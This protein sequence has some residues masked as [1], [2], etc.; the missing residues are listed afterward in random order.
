MAGIYI[1]IPF[2]KQACHYC[3]FHFSTNLDREAAVVDA[4][5]KEINLR[6]DFLEDKKIET[7]YLGGGTPSLISQE[8]FEKL[9]KHLSACFD[10]G[11]LKEFTLEANPDDISLEHLSMWKEIG[12]D[13]FSLGVQ[14]FFDEDLVYMN[15]SHNSAQS[16]KSIELIKKAKFKNFSI[17]LIYGGHT[18][19]AGMLLTNI[20]EAV[21]MDIPH[22]SVY[23]M[24]V[25]KKTALHAFIEKGDLEK[26]DNSKQALQFTLLMEQ[27]EEEGFEQY[28]ISNYC[29]DKKYAVH[30]TNYWK[31]K[32]YL[33]FGP[34]AHSFDGNQRTWNIA[35]NNAYV[36][37]IESNSSFGTNE[38]LS[39]K[40]K[41][42]EY[43][44]TGFRTKWGVQLKKIQNE[45]ESFSSNFELILEKQ[46]LAKTI[47]DENGVL[48]L[49]PDG[50][51]IADNVIAE[52]FATT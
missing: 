18:T 2:C 48:T 16:Y 30:N 52:F 34:S 9:L 45:F 20:N 15:R 26:L 17:D 44:L 23:G 11:D 13:R 32:P 40:D 28:E 1:H 43:L 49:T 24:T 38:I 21:Q 33:G 31:A 3:N 7:L 42:N 22:L 12:V 5:C 37:A 35:D 51:L 25:E 50:K 14:S 46:M 6:K 29:K 36:K 39:D 41:Y 19:T 10:L 27:M 8:S 4:I 47:S